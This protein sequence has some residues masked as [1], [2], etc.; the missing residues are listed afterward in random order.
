VT[1]L[2]V[3]VTD[4]EGLALLRRHP[5]YSIRFAAQNGTD[6]QTSGAT[7]TG[8]DSGQVERLALKVPEAEQSIGVSE[9]KVRELIAS[10]ELR[11]FH[12]DR[13]V[14]V[15]TSDLEQYLSRL[16]EAEAS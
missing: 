8:S 13:S 12:V 9:R 6:V 15:R 5:R 1:Y 14:R 2:V 4:P 7:R 11:A 16:V 10:G 3:V